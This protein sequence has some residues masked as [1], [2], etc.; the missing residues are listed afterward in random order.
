MQQFYQ[1]NHNVN[2]ILTLASLVEKEG[3]TDD[4]RKNIAS[5]F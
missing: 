1:S 5:V 3:A 2:E 4:D